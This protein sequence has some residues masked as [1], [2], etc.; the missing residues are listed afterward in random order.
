MTTQE[1]K[2]D[3]DNS[4]SQARAKLESIVEMVRSLD[5]RQCAEFYV[6][7]MDRGR[8]LE[9]LGSPHL[10]EDDDDSA[11]RELVMEEIMDDLITPDD[12]EFDEEAART[13]IQEDP[14]TVQWRSDWCNVGEEMQPGEFCIL[15]CTGGPAVRIIGD[16]DG[17]EPGNPRLQ[18]Q[19]WFT[20]WQ[21]L[22]G[23]TKE[24]HDALLTYCRQFYFGG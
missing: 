2:P 6:K 16:L 8:C 14:L 7:D 20:P 22:T 23:I 15:L 9:L 24:E 3:I 17:D 4:E 21:D 5:R 11:L 13:A 19:D 18:H 10:I 12:F 1:K